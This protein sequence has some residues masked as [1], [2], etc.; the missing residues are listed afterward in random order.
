MEANHGVYNFFDFLKNIFLLHGFSGSSFNLPSWSISVEFYTY[1]V[2]GLLLLTKLFFRM[3][4][5]IIVLAS[6]V[7]YFQSTG[8]IAKDYMNLTR[9]LFCFFL[10]CLAYEHRNT[11]AIAEYSEILF[12]ISSFV[13][14]LS[15]VLFKQFIF[16]LAPPLFLIVILS[17]FHLNKLSSVYKVLTLKFFVFLGSISYGIY[18]IHFCITIPLRH[19]LHFIF[20]YKI[21]E[22]GFLLLGNLQGFIFYI[23]IFFLCLLL[24]FLSFKYLESKWKIKKI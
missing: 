9:C 12:L 13:S 11:F 5:P 8:Y 6:L 4:I 15:I 18:M 24:S 23:L 17:A 7:I 3:T 1:L 14:I 19:V 21:D 16:L 2:F 10:G 20:G 22:N